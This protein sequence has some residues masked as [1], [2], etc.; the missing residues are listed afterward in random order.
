MWSKDQK[1]LEL[2]Y[3]ASDQLFRDGPCPSLLLDLRA[4][5][6]TDFSLSS[7]K[8]P[9]CY[10][11]IVS[12]C[13]RLPVAS[14]G[15]L[16]QDL[17]YTEIIL[18]FWATLGLLKALHKCRLSP[19]SHYTTPISCWGALWCCLR[20]I[21]LGLLSHISYYVFSL[22]L[23]ILILMKV[24]L[25]HSTTPRPKSVFRS[26][27]R[28]HAGLW[29]WGVEA[30]KAQGTGHFHIISF[31]YFPLWAFP[32]LPFSFPVKTGLCKGWGNCFHQI[33]CVVYVY[34]FFLFP[35]RA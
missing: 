16:S 4:S 31:L 13:D 8:G 5:W 24:D 35:S 15:R 3:P 32:L 30:V 21:C 22:P 20:P 27:S 19:G 12:P 14:S 29:G 33:Y 11:G 23:W 28:T 26:Y 34:K 2:F 18:L 6:E 25:L 10:M 17:G 7:V 1:W 9:L